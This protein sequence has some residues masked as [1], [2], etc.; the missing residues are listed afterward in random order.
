MVDRTQ[1]PDG[2]AAVDFTPSQLDAIEDALEDLEVHDDLQALGLDAQST[3]RLAE[4]QS[5]LAMTR[6]AFDDQEPAPAL[7]TGVLAEARQSASIAQTGAHLAKPSESTV[8]DPGR[9][10]RRF[11]WLPWLALTASAAAVLLIIKPGREPA[12]ST[13]TLADASDAKRRD[14]GAEAMAADRPVA[15]RPNPAEASA[16]T[17]AAQ[18]SDDGDEDPA[19]EL[20][21]EQSTEPADEPDPKTPEPA[22]KSKTSSAPSQAATKSKPGTPSTAGPTPEEATAVVPDKDT[23][24]SRLTRAHSLRRRGECQS[25]R[26]IYGALLAPELPATLRAQAQAGIGLCREYEG[27]DAAAQA[28]FSKARDAL[29]DID[30]W[31]EAERDEMQAVGKAPKKKRAKRPAAADAFGE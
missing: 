18:A 19:P 15:E 4:Y 21:E 3:A 6:E 22:S 7:L 25:A 29:R 10:R 5:I 14:A 28:D 12:A 8:D 26:S 11:A 31:V 20:T 17:V 2:D 13:E 24:W 16:A 23:A 30:G 9:G 1:R 27:N